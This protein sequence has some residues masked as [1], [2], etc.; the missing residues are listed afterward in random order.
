[1][2][3]LILRFITKI[4]HKL[5]FSPTDCPI[6]SNGPNAALRVLLHWCCRT[7]REKDP[8]PALGQNVKMYYGPRP[9]GKSMWVSRPLGQNQ[10]TPCFPEKNIENWAWPLGIL[11][12]FHQFSPKFI[13]ILLSTLSRNNMSLSETPTE[14]GTDLFFL[15]TPFNI[16]DRNPS[17]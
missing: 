1:M 14:P 10:F 3:Y 16:T 9:L 8:A 7:S 17:G 12:I 4:F 15:P 6:N 11:T 2:H 5:L 13:K